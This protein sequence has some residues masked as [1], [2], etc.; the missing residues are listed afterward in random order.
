MNPSK[1]LVRFAALA[2]IVLAGV[3]SASAYSDCENRDRVATVFQS[4][5]SAAGIIAITDQ[6]YRLS[7]IEV[8]STN[9]YRFQ[10]V[11]VANQGSYNKQWWWTADR[12]EASF[13]K[14]AHDRNAR[15]IDVEYS[16]VNGQVRLAGTFVR[17]AEQDEVDWKLFRDLSFAQLL[18]QLGQ[19]DGRVVDIEA[20]Q[21]GSGRLYSGIMIRNAGEFK[22]P[23]LVF[24]GRTQLQVENLAAANNMQLLDL[25]RV[26]PNEFAGVMGPASNLQWQGYDKTWSE[27]QFEV[28]QRKGRIIDLERHVTSGNI[29][30]NY[31][32][33]N[34]GNAVE[35]RVGELLRNG[36]DGVVGFHYREVNGLELGAL[37]PDQSIYP[38]STIK[39][40]QHLYWT[41]RVDMGLSSNTL[42]PVYTNHTADTHGPND[43]FVNRR[44]WQTQQNMMD[45]SSNSDTNALQDAAGN[46][47]GVLGRQ[48][49]NLFKGNILGIGTE[50]MLNHK[51]G[52]G[53]PNNDPA[54]VATA[55][56]LTRVYERCVD[57]SVISLGGFAYLRTNMLNDSD[58]ITFRAALWNLTRQFQLANGT[59][60]SAFQDYWSRVRMVWKGGNI[61]TAYVSSAGWITLPYRQRDGRVVNRQFVLSAFVDNATVNSIGSVSG[62]VLPQIVLDQLRESFD[63]F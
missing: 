9:P 63:T 44:L 11:F 32:L 57:G 55:R 26:G 19:F 47:D 12:S 18:S 23:T 10:G 4:N 48:R 6:G 5:L 20:R 58:N 14:F 8:T 33:A 46:G 56:S 42:V 29:R 34:N 15:P 49:I 7:D 41:R 50:M 45:N 3:Q 38:A 39:I 60:E 52:A 16:F 21:V 59:P 53:G 62:N 51:F 31:V 24:A 2:G 17:N 36:S 28:A 25:E 54:N 22:Q 35:T 13:L 30:Y 37:L 27:V 1:T 40:L 43:P 61:G